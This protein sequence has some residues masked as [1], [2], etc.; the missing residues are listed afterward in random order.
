M[1]NYTEMEMEQRTPLTRVQAEP[2]VGLSAEQVKERFA[3]HADNYKVESS[4]MSVSDI[5][6]SA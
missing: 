1:G 6:K 3:C 5:V 2:G 4:T